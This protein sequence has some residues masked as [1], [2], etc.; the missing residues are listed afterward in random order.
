MTLDGI[1]V[2]RGQTLFY[3]HVTAAG[4]KSWK[5]GQV[6]DVNEIPPAVSTVTRPLLRYHGGKWLLAPW[7]LNH[8][9]DHRVYVE[10]FGGAASV[11]LQKQRSYAEVYNDLDGEVV[12]LFNVARDRG[13]E[14]VEALRLTPFAR[15][16]FEVAWNPT[17]DPVE[18]AR[19]TVVR[20]FMG[21]G[22]AAVT[23]TRHVTMARGG[24]P[25]TGFRAN[26]NRSGTTPAHDWAN[27][28]DVLPAIV[29]RLQGVVI[30]NRDALEVMSQHDTPQ[31]LH[32][33]DPPYVGSTRDNGTDYLFEMS[34]DQH[35]QLAEVLH[36]LKGMVILSG[37][38]SNLYDELYA[39]WR[40]EE[41]RALADGARE[42]T[43]VLWFSPNVP[44]KQYSLFEKEK[45]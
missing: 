40:Y 35:R 32:Y 8:F 13:D 44:P 43:E 21:F 39:D 3:P 5:H 1:P 19:R 2:Q 14:L 30:E 34:D 18:Q 12:N 33:V 16:E 23:M 20:S 17:T 31:T 37:Y 22:S 36:G 24:K 10:P 25:G 6:M 41:R 42:R 28:P 26:S 11:L 15:T 38:H 9:H 7:I 4:N 45:R 27:Y 29:E